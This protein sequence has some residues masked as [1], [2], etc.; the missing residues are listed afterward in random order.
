MT[1]QDKLEYCSSEIIQLTDD[2]FKTCK[3]SKDELAGF[4]FWREHVIG[5][6]N[7]FEVDECMHGLKRMRQLYDSIVKDKVIQEELL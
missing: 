4:Q 7:R 5:H 1:F 6:L 2:W 3:P